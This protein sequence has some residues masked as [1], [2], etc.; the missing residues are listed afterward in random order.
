MIDIIEKT[1]GYGDIIVIVTFHITHPIRFD[2]ISLK[3][4][5]LEVLLFQLVWQTPKRMQP[6]TRRSTTLPCDEIV[7]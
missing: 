5:K 4:L 3:L 6:A 1:N 7:L 2:S